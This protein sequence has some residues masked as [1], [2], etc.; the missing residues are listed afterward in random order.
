MSVPLA[1][2]IEIADKKVKPSKKK[3]SAALEF[4]HQ[5][6]Y[7]PIFAERVPLLEAFK[8]ALMHYLMAQHANEQGDWKRR[9]AARFGLGRAR[10]NVAECGVF[11]GNSMLAVG[12]L[13]TE[14]GVPF[15]MYGMDTFEGLPDL[16]QID[17]EMAPE[18]A[19]YRN[20]RMFTET[21]VDLV[22]KKL[23]D[24]G[25]ADSFKLVKG[26]FSDTLKTLPEQ[27]YH[28]VNVDCD[29]Y[30]PHLECLEYFYQRMERGGILF[31]DDYNSTDYPMAKRAIDEFMKGKPE[32]ICS[33]RYGDDA[34][35]RTKAFIIKF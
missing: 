7:D 21:S 3:F 11:N 12:R 25:L 9:L 22:Q 13:A 6:P 35:N 8:L 33:L 15:F 2:N 19:R 16:S 29:L 1:A 32:R 17:S 18:K 31:F 26:L 5:L 34:A 23:A 20:E 14:A 24:A 28:F 27:T 10:F 4:S 30:E